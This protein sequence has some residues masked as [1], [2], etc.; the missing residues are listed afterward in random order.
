MTLLFG[1]RH[2]V[3]QLYRDELTELSRSFPHFRALYTLSQ[4]GPGWSGLTGYVQTHTEALWRELAAT[5]HGEPH[6]YVCGLEHMVTAVRDLLRKQL[7]VD[8]KQVHSER[9]D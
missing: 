1:V 8:R 5:G 9:Y 4:P 7:G 2:E 3:D 6:L